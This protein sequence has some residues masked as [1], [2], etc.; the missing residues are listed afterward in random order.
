MEAKTR[1]AKLAKS[2]TKPL[3]T[4]S[5]CVPPKKRAQEGYPRVW[6]EEITKKKTEKINENRHKRRFWRSYAKTDVALKFYAKN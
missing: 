4:D 1:A 2:T 3:K 6:R 5:K